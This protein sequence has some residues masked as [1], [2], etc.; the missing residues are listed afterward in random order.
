MAVVATSAAVGL[1]LGGAANLISSVFA[2]EIGEE[3]DR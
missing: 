2:V 1:M 3:V